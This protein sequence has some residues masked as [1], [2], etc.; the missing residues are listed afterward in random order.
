MKKYELTEDVRMING[1][2]LYR[3]KAIRD[4][5]DVRKG[6]LGGY[7][8]S[9]RNLDHEGNAWVDDHAKVYDAA[10]VFDNAWVCDEACVREN[11]AVGENTYVRDHAEIRGS[12]L[13]S[14]CASINGDARIGGEANVRGNAF[15]EDCAQ[16][17]DHA[18]VEG[19]AIISGKAKI[20]WRAYIG[21]N[22][23]INRD[24]YIETDKDHLAIG[25]IGINSINPNKG[26][27]ITFFR[28]LTGTKVSCGC[29]RGTIEEFEAEVKKKYGENKYGMEYLAAIN[30]ARIKFGIR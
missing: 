8:E 18:L 9:E 7:I 15:V 25:P 28:S 6:R 2:R 21:S 4:F 17:E 11:A 26:M 22:E 29:F 20:I 13:V 27:Y 19:N 3:I 10:R 1:K 30:L 23:L 12:A 14:G 24:A 5:C 16:I